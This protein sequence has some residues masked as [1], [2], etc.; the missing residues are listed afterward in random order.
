V[1]FDEL[2]AEWDGEFL[3]SRFDAEAK[4]W[5][6]IGVHSTALGPAAGGTRMKPYDTVEDAIRDVLR[7]SRAM[8]FKNAMAGVP[9]G[10]GKAVLAVPSVPEGPERTGLLHRY[11]DLLASLG[12]SY[13]TA[14]DMNTSP[15]DMDV[16]AERADGVFGTTE[17]HGGSGSSAPD[18]AVGVYHGVRAALGQAFGSDDPAG[19]TIVIQGA[20]AVGEPLAGRLA[21]DGTSL[22]LT[23]VAPERAERVAASVGGTTVAA[24]TEYDV[25]CDLFAPCATGGVLNARTIPRLRCRAVAGAA[26]NQL[27]EPDDADRL[28]AA[29]ILYAPDYVVNAGGVLHLIGYERLGWDAQTMQERLAGIGDTLRQ[30]FAAAD[31]DGIT[32]AAAADA[33]ARARVEAAR[34]GRAARSA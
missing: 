18:T 14:C 16:I 17:A 25:A 34:A 32:P 6:L 9:F 26:N 29:G 4:A 10:G 3:A 30:V 20:G 11:G 24:G 23:D 21:V 19:R 7:L 1:A 28:A 2:L 13:V 31:A 5:I 12:G 22:V 27:L 15:A 8:T 33:I